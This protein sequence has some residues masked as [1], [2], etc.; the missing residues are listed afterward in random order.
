MRSSFRWWLSVPTLCLVLASLAPSEAVA[1]EP[2][3]QP[4]DL[5]SFD[6]GRPV[7]MAGPYW[8]I[9]SPHMILGVGAT[10]TVHLP[11]IIHA[12]AGY[13]Y[14]LSLTEGADGGMGT[15]WFEAYAGFPLFNWDSTTQISVPVNWYQSGDAQVVEYVNVEAPSH[16]SLV[17]EGGLFGG[18][19]VFT[20]QRMNMDGT[21]TT[22]VTDPTVLY[23]A[24]GAR[25]I[26][27][28][29]LADETETIRNHGMLYGHVLFGPVG[30]PSGDDVTIEN[31]GFIGT[32]SEEHS[33]R[34]VGV[35]LGW[36][37]FV[38]ADGFASFDI[39]VGY[40]PGAGT[41]YFALGNS[42]PIWLL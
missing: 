7:L 6:Q 27:F 34:I 11:G 15:D 31:S 2:A 25:W 1:Q 9:R 8:G 38:W 26:W 5:S 40:L 18:E 14:G 24:A 16:E 32:S 17:I 20:T 13:M 22:E 42:F 36:S 10:A 35:K 3:A 30:A 4:P 12:S 19:S 21:V 29:N 23:F 28:W 41:V 33:T 39:E 37:A